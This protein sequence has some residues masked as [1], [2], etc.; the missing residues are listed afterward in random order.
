MKTKSCLKQF[1]DSRH[2]RRSRAFGSGIVRQ[3]G[4]GWWIWVKTDEG[5]RRSLLDQRR[6][7]VL[8]RNPA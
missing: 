1:T 8:N 7:L 3:L 2:Q 4:L 5:M 6:F